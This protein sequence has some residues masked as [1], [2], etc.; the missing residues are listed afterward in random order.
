MRLW[1]KTKKC[2]LWVPQRLSRPLSSLALTLTSR[3]WKEHSVSEE[4]LKWAEIYSVDLEAW[5]LRS[6]VWNLVSMLTTNLNHMTLSHLSRFVFSSMFI[7]HFIEVCVT[8]SKMFKSKS[9][10]LWISAYVHA[11]VTT[12]SSGIVLLWLLMPYW[13][14]LSFESYINGITYHLFWVQLLLFS[15]IFLGLPIF[16]HLSMVLF[17]CAI[18]LHYVNLLHLINLFSWG[19]IKLVSSAWLLWIKLIGTF[20]CMSFGGINA[21][22]SQTDRRGPLEL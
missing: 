2:S 4:T 7:I 8:Y 15:I 22:I 16:L 19:V 17:H 5:S 20:L 14:C 18:V 13:L 12:A 10:V 6:K 1:T 21:R 11:L 9:T 3:H